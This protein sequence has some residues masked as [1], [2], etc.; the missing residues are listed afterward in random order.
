[1]RTSKSAAAALAAAAAVL[2]P[3]LAS[4]SP[5][6]ASEVALSPAGASAGSHLKVDAPGADAGFRSGQLPTSFAVAFGKGFALN[7]AAVAG[8]CTV[9]LA[10]KDQCPANSRLGAGAIGVELNGAHYTANLEFFRA[11]PPQA[12]D[13]GGIIFYFKEPQSGFNGASVGSVRSVD[14]GLYGQLI[15]FD[16][17]PLPALPPGLDL[18]LDRLQLDLG[19]GAATAPVAVPHHKKAKRRCLRHR[20]H[21]SKRHCVKWAKPKRKPKPAATASTSFILNPATCTGSW[22]VQLRWGYKDGTQELREATP[23]CTASR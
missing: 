9:A 12:G 23:A 13:E 10:N 1:M 19:A 22:P 15:T 16:K 11:D 14:D 18:Q 4:G 7:P 20:G 2:V 3:A 8:T 21:G 5:M 17:L 6:P